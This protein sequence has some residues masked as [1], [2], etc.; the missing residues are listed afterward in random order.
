[1]NIA[2]IHKLNNDDDDISEAEQTHAKKTIG[3]VELW[4]ASFDGTGLEVDTETANYHTSFTSMVGWL[5]V[6]LLCVC[7][8]TFIS[9]PHFAKE[10]V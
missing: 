1:M 10:A 5:L 6:F 7:R 2:D 4:C 8:E 9:F 3:R